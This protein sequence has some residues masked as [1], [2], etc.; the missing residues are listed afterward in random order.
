M[1]AYRFAAEEFLVDEAGFCR[2]RTG[3]CAVTYIASIN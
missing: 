3:A 1:M 2:I